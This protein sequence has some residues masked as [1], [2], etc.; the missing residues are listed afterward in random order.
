MLIALAPA[1]WAAEV[2]FTE[3]APGLPF[4]AAVTVDN[5]VYL[6]GQLGAAPGEMQVVPGGIEPETHQMMKNI[7]ATLQSLGL[8]L[9]SVVKCTV[10]LA[11]IAEWGQ[12]NSIYTQYFEAPYPARSAF[13]A[14]GLALN[15]RVEMECMAV[16]SG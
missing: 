10:M 9:A 16:K 1:A 2:A 3:A 14:S 7:R 12:F 11:D 5:T 13:G 8:D 15:A 6:A 4:S